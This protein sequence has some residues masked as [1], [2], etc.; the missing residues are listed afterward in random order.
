MSKVKIIDKKSEK[1]IILEKNILVK[2]KHPFIVNMICTF[3]DY[4]NLYLLMDL[5]T[6]GDLRYHFNKKGK[7]L[8][9]ELRFFISCIIL[10]LDYIHSNN[11]IH[12]DIK[13]ENL[14]L[15]E[16]GYVHLTD[17]GI[18][19]IK[20]DEN[21][22][23]TSGTPSYMAPEVLLS[24][25]HSFTIDYYAIGIIGYE[26]LIGRRPFIGKTRKEI[27]NLVLKEEASIKDD[28]NK[29][30]LWSKNCVDFINSCLKKKV[31]QRIGFTS[32]IKELKSHPW[33]ENFDWGELYNK[34]I[35][36]PF[37]PDIFSYL[38]KNIYNSPDDVSSET[39]ERYQE[40]MKESDYE[41]K[42]DG[43]TYI[44]DDIIDYLKEKKDLPLI[45]YI[46]K[47]HPKIVIKEE[48]P[49]INE[50]KLIDLNYIK[51]SPSSKKFKEYLSPT[52]TCKNNIPKNIMI[53]P[54]ISINKTIRT[55]KQIS[56]DNIILSNKDKKIFFD[57]ESIN[58]IFKDKDFINDKNYDELKLIFNNI[59]NRFSKTKVKNSFNIESL[60]NSK[61]NIHFCENQNKMNRLT[62]HVQFFIKDEYGLNI[63]SKFKNY[64]KKKLNIYS[65]ND[66]KSNPENDMTKK[67]DNSQGKFIPLP[68]L[69]KNK[70]SHSLFN[71]IKQFNF[72]IDNKK[73]IKMSN[74]IQNK[75]I[76]NDLLQNKISSYYQNDNKENIRKF[77]PRR[78]CQDKLKIYLY[79]QNSTGYFPTIKS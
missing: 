2:L 37:L 21:H 77:N 14:L 51:N 19:R 57:K 25:N 5:F 71:S 49:K 41:K 63:P 54:K 69:R 68:Y 79:K 53:I 42:F 36:A 30:N 38:N 4:D 11:I 52:P 18:A 12:R 56:V 67:T 16:K 48:V 9:A 20:K 46:T 62:K 28:D 64:T 50:Q 73:K 70:N 59:T 1:N 6:G 32:G 24:Q 61:K 72:K 8:E 39:L 78:G 60:S 23:E 55:Q 44:S 22:S 33:F 65:L 13:P 27:R 31:E 10:S 75:I 34:K 45:E 29:N 76:E 3:Q 35:K 15:D 43:Y 26:F 58:S 47:N 7:F 74:F 17:F 40:Y 66:T